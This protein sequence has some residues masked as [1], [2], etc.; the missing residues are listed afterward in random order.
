M[1]GGSSSERNNMYLGYD[2]N[3]NIVT[4]DPFGERGESIR[5]L[6]GSNQLSTEESLGRLRKMAKIKRHIQQQAQIEQ[7]KAVE[8]ARSKAIQKAQAKAKAFKNMRFMQGARYASMGRMYSQM[9]GCY[10]DALTPHHVSGEYLASTF[11]RDYGLSGADFARGPMGGI[12]SDAAKKLVS[13]VYNKMLAYEKSMADLRTAY[14]KLDKAS[15]QY[16]KLKDAY[17]KLVVAYTQTPVSYGGMNFKSRQEAA[18]KFAAAVVTG[19]ETFDKSL[20]AEIDSMFNNPLAYD[21]KVKAG[22]TKSLL[23]GYFG[24]EFDMGFG[25]IPIAA[26]VAVGAALSVAG[27]AAANA[28]LSP[29]K[30]IDEIIA[31]TDKMIAEATTPEQRAALVEQRKTLV[32]AKAKDV[33]TKSVTGI[34][35]GVTEGV[36]NIVKYAGWAVALYAVWKIGLPLLQA[37]TAGMAKAST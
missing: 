34:V 35:T 30:K 12:A 16:K 1:C 22:Q 9:G 33:A 29:D 37:K 2:E 10:G 6:L 24:S 11:K 36:G 13:G 19:I 28:A 32:E 21:K 3:G 17:D 31:S 27:V 14:R 8:R 26:W 5:P 7:K 18:F 4:K 15:P 25:A 20:A 23:A